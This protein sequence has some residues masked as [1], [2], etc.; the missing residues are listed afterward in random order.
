[1][2]ADAIYQSLKFLKLANYSHIYN[3][4]LHD[5]VI[6]NSIITTMFRHDIAVDIFSIHYYSN[7]KF[8]GP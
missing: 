8:I 7:H 1:M 3:I 5:Y 6:M 4:N 2:S